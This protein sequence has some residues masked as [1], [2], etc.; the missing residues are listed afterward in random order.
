VRVVNTLNAAA[1]TILEQMRRN[2]ITQTRQVIS[3]FVGLG[4]IVALPAVLV[5]WA[6][7]R[8]RP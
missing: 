6:R 4:V 1:M 5:Y 8:F 7:K 2:P 3:A